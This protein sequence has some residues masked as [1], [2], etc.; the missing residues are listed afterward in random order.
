MTVE[1]HSCRSSSAIA[2]EIM[3]SNWVRTSLALVVIAAGG[4]LAMA[5]AP[6]S[7]E[8]RPISKPGGYAQQELQSI[9]QQSIGSGYTSAS[10]SNSI[11][12]S[13][14]GNTPSYRRPN[15]VSVGPRIGTGIGPS[16]SPKPFNSY[17]PAPTVS[18]Y[19]N[20]FREDL[21][22]G[23]D[24]NYNTL[25]RPMLQQQQFNQQVQR[26][27]LELE[28]RLQSFAA[29]SDFNPQGSTQQLPTGH[30]TVFRYYGRYYPGMNARYRR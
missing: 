10:V 18:P 12:N 14:R 3:S 25:V 9:Y 15:P 6:L 29:Q 2:S 16:A 28:R 8:F 13:A 1:F 26:Q 17:S 4:G 27:S 5:Q 30:Q 21:A 22:G 20:L 19:L 11:M 23:S 7:G 24:L